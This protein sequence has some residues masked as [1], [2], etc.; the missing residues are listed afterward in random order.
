MISEVIV[1]HAD[2]QPL[3][4]VV[5][6][7]PHQTYRN[8]RISVEQRQLGDLA[9]DEIRV[10]MLYAG[11][12]GT[13][14]HLMETNPLTGYIRSSAPAY[15]PIQGRIIGH[16]GVGKILAVGS[17]VQHLKPSA[18]VAFESIIVC[19]HCESCR[20]GQFNQ[21]RHAKLLGLE[22]NGLFA[23]LADVPA[24]L[25]HDVTPLIK[26]EQDIRS[27]ACIEPAGVAY[28]ACQKTALN[29]GENVVIFGAGPVGLFCAMLART[30]FGAAQ[31]VMVEPVLF[32][33]QLAQAWCDHVYDVEEFFATSHRYFDVVIE[34][35]GELSNINRLFRQIN[36]NGRVAILA[37][38]GMPLMLDATDHMITNAIS[39]VGSRGH[40]GGAYSKLMNL[41]KSGRFPLNVPV[42]KVVNGLEEL[43]HLLKSPGEI[44][45]DNCK[46]LVKVKS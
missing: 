34:A 7:G 32:R 17:Q 38:S 33:R 4:G 30:V 2:E 43:S 3:A 12:C 39:I 21:C 37:R 45:H 42:T 31:T 27:C 19:Y 15:I 23:T 16:E 9:T 5:P 14:M 40:L 24:S 13:D 22:K 44:L 26:T 28:V 8:P 46:V 25:A 29:G 11:V 41:Y 6:D 35:S 36:A 20:Q 1:V 18:Y 10:E